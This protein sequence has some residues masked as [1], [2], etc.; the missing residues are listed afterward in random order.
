[1]IILLKN[2]VLRDMDPDLY[3]EFKTACAYF[4]LS[5]KKVLIGHMQNIVFDYRSS[6]AMSGKPI[7]DARKG[8][9]KI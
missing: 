6:K 7:L 4:D 2:Y 1:M 8:G 9:K 5:M 3:R